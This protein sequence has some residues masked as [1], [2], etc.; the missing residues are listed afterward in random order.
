MFP[1]VRSQ[2]PQLSEAISGLRPGQLGSSAPQ[3]ATQLVPQP[4]NPPPSW[5][6]SNWKKVAISLAILVLLGAGGY[7]IWK[8]IQKNKNKNKS[9]NKEGKDN[10]PNALPGRPPHID[11]IGQ[12]PIPVGQGPQMRMGPGGFGPMGPMGGSMGPGRPS[13]YPQP[14]EAQQSLRGQPDLLPMPG[15]DFSQGRPGMTSGHLGFRERPHNP[16]DQYLPPQQQGQSQG[17]WQMPG[18]WYQQ[19]QQPGMHPGMPQG[20]PQGPQGFGQG[21]TIQSLPGNMPMPTGGN[22]GGGWSPMDVAEHMVQTQQ[23]GGMGMGMGGG[24]GGGF[25]GQDPNFTAL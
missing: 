25:P 5:W 9:E 14:G 23:P 13:R 4:L 17:Q 22:P 11:Q 19:Q 16:Y 20:M 1:G 15:A 3:A 18:G 7:G 2:P 10:D 21:Q 24:G 6:E 8:L 12:G